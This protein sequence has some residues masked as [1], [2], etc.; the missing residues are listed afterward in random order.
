MPFQCLL[1]HQIPEMTHLALPDAMDAP[2]TLFEPVRIPRQVVI[3][4]EVRA[5]QVDPFA[6][7]I[8]RKQDLHALVLGERFLRL[9]PLVA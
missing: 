2:E 5:L 6:R 4:H 3:D 8:G 1:R 7:G 9:A